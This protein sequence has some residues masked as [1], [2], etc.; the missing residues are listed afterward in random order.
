[1]AIT[2]H[3][4]TICETEH[5]SEGEPGHGKGWHYCRTTQVTLDETWKCSGH[6]EATNRDFVVEKVADDE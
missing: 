4:R 2:Y 6:T 5:A 3:V 1:M